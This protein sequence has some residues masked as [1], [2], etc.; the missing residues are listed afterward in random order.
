MTHPGA[1]NDR[2]Q[3]LRS[4]DVLDRAP[5]GAFDDLTALAADICDAPMALLSFVDADRQLITSGRGI[6]VTEIPRDLSLCAHVVDIAAPLEVPDTRKDRR[7]AAHSLVAGHPYA[8]FYAGVPIITPDGH[9]L[10]ALSVL[11]VEPRQLS[12]PAGRHLQTLAD[13]VLTSMELRRRARR[14]AADGRSRRV[15]S[16]A[17]REQLRVLD[18]VLKHSDVLIFAK[19]VHGRF[20]MA[21]PALEHLTRSSGG[22]I[23]RTDYDLFDQTDADRFRENDNHILATKQWQVFTEDMVHP[24]GSAHT[25]RSTKFPLIGDNGEVIGVGGVSTDVTE[26]AAARA[27]H[28]QAEQRWRALIEQ[29]PA[30]VVVVDE[31][32]TVLYANPA[33]DRLCGAPI[34]ATAGMDLV[35]PR[36]RAAAKKMLGDILAGA[37]APR[38]QRGSLRRSDGTEFTVEFNATAVNHAGVRGVQLEVRDISDVAAAHAALKQSASTDALTGLLNRQAWDEQVSALLQHKVSR[39]LPMTVAV[40]DLDNFKDYNDTR[41]HTA[42]DALL[43]RFSEAAEATLREDDVLAR[44]GGEEFIVA[45]PAT[46]PDQAETVLQRI[47]RC[48]PFGQTCSIGYTSHDPGEALTD[49]VIR[50]DAALYRAKRQGRNQLAR[51]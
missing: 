28:A 40:I 29:S 4:Y 20:L 3:A 9:A 22:L 18:G 45:L 1:E 21:N 48:V 38:G 24:D 16:A 34:T 11:D 13:Q 37:T 27:A 12:G 41:G 5:D 33:A 47:K 10:G 30:A 8:R 2:L 32:G 36:L 25:Y 44:W 49:T 50:A 15:A 7:F 17:L 46:T 31:G 14:T 43:Q 6:A 26:L 19:D 42:G 35:H 23:G 51:S 39:G